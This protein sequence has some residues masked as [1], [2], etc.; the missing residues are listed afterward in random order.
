[1][2]VTEAIRTRLEIREFRDDS[3]DDETIHRVLDAGRLAA[4]GRNLQHWRF[5]LV[6]DPTDLNRLSDLSSTGH[7]VADAAFAVVICTDPSLSFNELDAGRALTHM[8]LV[9]WAA[10]VGSCIYTV[11]NPTV[12]EF[13][14]IPDH[15]D[16]TTVI[17]FGYPAQSVKGRKSRN[18]LTELAFH[19]RFNEPYTVK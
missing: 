17:G 16:L 4:S 8:Q 9:A 18:P 2:D 1:M 11:D 14:E 5:I 10:G 15:Y 6:D 3:V 12:S 13:L 7:W 19:G